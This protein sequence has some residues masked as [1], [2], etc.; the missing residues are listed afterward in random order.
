MTGRGCWAEEAEG[1]AAPEVEV[2]RVHRDELS[3]P[4]DEPAGVNQRLTV[5]LPHVANASRRT[6]GTGVRNA[7][8]LRRERMP[9]TARPA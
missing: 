9:Q 5:V 2:D 7:L 3:E 1:L 8:D 4:L 6:S